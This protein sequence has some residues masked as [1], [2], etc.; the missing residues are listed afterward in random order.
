MLWE[1]FFRQN[2]L[3]AYD[4]VMKC[5]ICSE[6]MKRS[7]NENTDEIFIIFTRGEAGKI[8]IKPRECLFSEKTG[9]EVI[10]LAGNKNIQKG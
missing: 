10:T 8:S 6:D 7:I 2:L 9:G 4:F 3:N 1:T 5:L